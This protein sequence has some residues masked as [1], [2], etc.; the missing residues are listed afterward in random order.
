MYSST[1]TAVKICQM[2]AQSASEREAGQKS[3]LTPYVCT[4]QR[5]VT[6]ISCASFYLTPPLPRSTYPCSPCCC[7]WQTTFISAVAETI[8]MRRERNMNC[9]FADFFFRFSQKNFSTFCSSFFSSTGHVHR[10]KCL[11]IVACT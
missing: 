3:R 10:R 4:K 2:L 6:E 8:N 9:F 7:L 11:S 5:L 1:K